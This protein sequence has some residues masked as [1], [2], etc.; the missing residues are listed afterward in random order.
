VSGDLWWVQEVPGAG[1]WAVGTNGIVVRYDPASGTVADVSTG[2]DATLFGLWGSGPNDVWVVGA[3]MSG[4]ALLR[5]N[6]TTWGAVDFPP[7]VDGFP[8]KIEGLAANDL[9]ACGTEG[10]LMH[11]NGLAWASVPSGTGTTL[12]TIAFGGP[13]N[14]LGFAVGEVYAAEIIERASNGTWAPVILPDGVASV[15]GVS[16]SADGDAW[17][18]GYGA[19]VLHRVEGNWVTVDGVP[20]GPND[21]VDLHTVSVDAEGGVWFA[22]GNI[23]Q[24]GN[25]TLLY[26]GSRAL[27]ADASLVLPQAPWTTVQPLLTETCAIVTCHGP[28]IAEADMDLST[29]ELVA[30]SLRRIPSTESPLLRIL[31]GRPSGS[32]LW[33]KLQ[34]TQDGVGGSGETMPKEGTLTPEQID[35]IRAWIL[36]G[37]PAG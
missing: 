17:A 21:G 8:Y 20:F 27:G 23:L 15:A 35:Q 3:G 19:T 11:W 29:P 24:H 6:G 36:E 34:G 1:I 37:S 31:P 9:Y 7:D 25:G 33:H 26:Y 30:T 4:R 2:T 32:Y 22:G 5:W 10:L 18:S 13:Q 12:L 28:P 14:S 16:I